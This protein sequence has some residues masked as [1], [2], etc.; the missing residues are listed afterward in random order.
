MPPYPWGIFRVSRTEDTQRAARTSS[1]HRDFGRPW[2]PFP[3][4][5]LVLGRYV[6]KLDKG[7]KWFQIRLRRALFVAPIGKVMAELDA[8]I[9]DA[10]RDFFRVFAFKLFAEAGL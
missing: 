7:S 5:L 3:F 2:N 1:A 6:D 9:S 8:E 4:P 10:V